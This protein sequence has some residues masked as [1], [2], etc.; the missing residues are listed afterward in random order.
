LHSKVS[1]NPARARKATFHHLMG[2]MTD[3]NRLGGVQSGFPD[4]LATAQVHHNIAGNAFLAFSNVLISAHTVNVLISAHTVN[5]L[6]SAH[7]EVSQD[8]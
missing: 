6:I 3:M 5:V 4:G 7:R 2:E 1:A 8:G